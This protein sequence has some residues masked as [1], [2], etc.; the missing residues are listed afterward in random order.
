MQYNGYKLVGSTMC[1]Q[2]QYSE[3]SL[4]G[5]TLPVYIQA[6]QWVV[7]LVVH[8]VDSGSRMVGNTH[9]V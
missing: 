7:W 6:V 2:W 4:V 8:Y 5:S 1:T 9:P 3:Y